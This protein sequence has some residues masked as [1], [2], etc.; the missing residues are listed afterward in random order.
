MASLTNLLIA[1]SYDGLL[2]TTD[3]QPLSASLVNI[4][5]GLGN[6]SALN[7]S[8]NQINVSGTLTVNSNPVVLSSQTASMAVASAVS[9][10]YALSASYEVN[11]ETSSSYADTA[12]SSSYSAT[13]TSSS[14]AINATSSSYAINATSASYAATATSSSYAINATSASYA[15]TPA[16]ASYALS[17]SYAV[18]ASYAPNPTTASYALTASFWGGGSAYVPYTGS[19]DD[20]RLDTNSIYAKDFI[21]TYPGFSPLLAAI[22]ADISSAPGYGTIVIRRGSTGYLVP[23]ASLTVDRTWLLPDK[24]GVV[25]VLTNDVLTLIPQDP[26][27]AANLNPYS[28]AVSGSSPA[29]PYFSDGSTW[30]A[31]Y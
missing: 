8:T 1:D 24:S 7:L 31:L 17:A 27:P 14:Y 2:T 13:A 22:G 3:N 28:F 25:A 11:Y 12:V 10:S 9:A 6:A 18:S 5:D 29:K 4:A 21:A 30:N 19:T 23:T 16:T 15:P 26:L 20:V